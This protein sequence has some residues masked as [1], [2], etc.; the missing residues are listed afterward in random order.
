ML[1]D[2]TLDLLKKK[3]IIVTPTYIFSDGLFHSKLLKMHERQRRLGLSAETVKI[4]KMEAD[5]VGKKRE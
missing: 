4:K 5:D 2:T 1:V 3:G